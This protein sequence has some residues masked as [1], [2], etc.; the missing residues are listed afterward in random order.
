[1]HWS[2]SVPLL[3]AIGIGSGLV[4]AV[5]I[6]VLGL[7]FEKY[8][9]LAFGIGLHMRVITVKWAC[10]MGQPVPHMNHNISLLDWKEE[11][12]Q[13]THILP[14]ILSHFTIGRSAGYIES[15]LR[16]LKLFYSPF[17]LM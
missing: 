1:M 9:P 13:T 6:V 4:Y 15:T 12:K 10:L 14:Q 17:Y 7:Y 3:P 8:R 5:G 2:N 16:I 11:P